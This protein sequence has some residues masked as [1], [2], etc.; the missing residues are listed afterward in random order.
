MTITAA[1]AVALGA[2]GEA[3]T[4][5][6]LFSLAEGLERYAVARARHGLRVLL[7]LV[8]ATATVRS[9]SLER[10]I[11]PAALRVECDGVE[12]EAERAELVVHPVRVCLAG[13][14]APTLAHGPG[15]FA[16]G[17]S[18]SE[19]LVGP[20]GRTGPDRMGPAR[21]RST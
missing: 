20:P 16:A 19:L 2:Q 4:L 13:G 14:A 12:D 21:E 8:P 15:L 7:A 9:D 3:G 6:D 18:D 17:L 11:D 10:E 1:G 5:A